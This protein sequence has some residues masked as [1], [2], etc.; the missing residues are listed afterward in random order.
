MT[1]LLR[2]QLAEILRDSSHNFVITEQ[3]ELDNEAYF[4]RLQCFI[5]ALEG[6]RNEAYYD[7]IVY[8]KNSRSFISVSKF[9]ALDPQKRDE[10]EADC[11]KINGRKP[12][13]TI[14]IGLNFIYIV[15]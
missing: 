10:L 14:G 1:K 4:T 11:I 3:N 8:P 2:A 6:S 7:G 9:N 5:E 13:V 12:I 15:F